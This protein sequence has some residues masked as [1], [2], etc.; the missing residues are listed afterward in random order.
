MRRLVCV[1]EAADCRVCGSSRRTSEGRMIEPEKDQRRSDDRAVDAGVL[2]AS[3]VG[4]EAGRG[5]DRARRRA[6]LVAVLSQR[7]RKVVALERREYQLL[8]AP[9]DVCEL[10][11]DVLLKLAL[12][13]VLQRP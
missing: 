5:D 1:G 13:R 7:Q 12:R 8:L 3:H 11:L 2:L 4:V 6:G 10:A 9:V